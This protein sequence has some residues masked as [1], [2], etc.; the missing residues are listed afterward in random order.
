MKQNSKKNW[1]L[2]EEARKLRR[3]GWT[4]KEIMKRVPVHKVT[5]SKWCKD[6]K[7]TPEQI[8]SRGGRYANRLK[9]AKANQFKREKE[10]KK[11]LM[12]AKK[13][14]HPLTNYEFKVAGAMLYWAEGNKTSNPGISNSDPKLIEF[15]MEWFRKICNVAEKKI[16]ASLYLHTGLDGD[17]MKRY[18]SKL[19]DIPLNRFGKTIFKQEGEASRKNSQYKG[20]IKIQIFDEDLKHRI[21]SWIK[22]LASNKR[23]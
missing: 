14:I 9:G 15:A 5:L 4:Y 18:W 7:L 19:T 23:P 20:T 1:Q 2:K 10:I 3:L 22:E 6:I 8:A 16:K 13:E 11:I 17:K 21:L 12:E